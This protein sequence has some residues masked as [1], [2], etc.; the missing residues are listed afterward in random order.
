MPYSNHLVYLPASEADF[1]AENAV[2]I[3]GCLPQHELD[4]WIPQLIRT[5]RP[6]AL[7]SI[8]VIPPESI[9]RLAETAKRRRLTIAVLHAY[10]LLPIFA[11]M[12]ELL[13]SNCFGA[14][15]DAKV[16]IP[17]TGSPLLCADL[18]SWLC[19]NQ[20]E[21]S[22]SDTDDTQIAMSLSADNGSATAR[23]DLTSYASELTIHIFGTVRRFA[24]P[25]AAPILAE[26]DI[27]ANTV[28][29]KRK[30]PLLM[31]VEDAAAAIGRL[32]RFSRQC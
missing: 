6:F 9:I 23:F 11:R 18:A 13:A 24:I 14:L 12:K 32:S 21:T 2:P 26:K 25:Y 27:L 15:R 29:C 17:K 28:P 20:L 10:R 4:E 7:D 3:L 31:H 16:S 8:E 19:Q 22:L 30:W 5:K 1:T